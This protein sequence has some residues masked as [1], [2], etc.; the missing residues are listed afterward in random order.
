M[1]NKLL[2]P[3]LSIP[4]VHNQY[5]ILLRLSHLNFLNLEDIQ[6]FIFI[7]LFI[8]HH[9]LLH[10]N[11]CLV[12]YHDL[13]CTLVLLMNYFSGYKQIIIF[14]GII[15]YSDGLKYLI[16]LDSLSY[17]IMILMVPL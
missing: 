12:H 2:S 10:L 15:N 5:Q 6:N 8:H 9:L 13:H 14:A 1:Q 3:P 11:L 17:Q 7:H 16:K 4:P